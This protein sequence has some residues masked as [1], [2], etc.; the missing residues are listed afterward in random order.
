MIE[1]GKFKANCKLFEPT[2][3]LKYVVKLFEPHAKLLGTSLKFE[4]TLQIEL[5]V[6]LLGDQIR[7]KQVLINIVKN[8]LNK[9]HN[10]NK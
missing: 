8:S 1:Q 4:E 2:S 7:L 3:L 6:R 5:P 10:G 9:T